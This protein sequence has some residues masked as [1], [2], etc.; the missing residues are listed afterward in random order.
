M[1]HR[2]GGLGAQFSIGIG[3]PNPI[4]LPN[5]LPVNEPQVRRVRK[6]LALIV[7]EYF[8]SGLFEDYKG[9]DFDWSPEVLDAG[10]E[11]AYMYQHLL[12][13]RIHLDKS[14]S[15]IT[16]GYAHG[17][18]GTGIAKRTKFYGEFKRSC[19]FTRTVDKCHAILYAKN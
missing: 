5:T 9:C 8:S 16:R 19:K 12:I 7:D 2:I 11:P 13:L 15:K 4:E 18:Y 14:K 6:A 17:A 10:I 1:R 3:N